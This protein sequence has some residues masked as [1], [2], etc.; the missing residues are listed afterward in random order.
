VIDLRGSAADRGL[1]VGGDGRCHRARIVGLRDLAHRAV[2]IAPD[3]RLVDIGVG[4]VALRVGE[5]G[6]A[7][8]RGMGVP[9]ARHALELGHALRDEPLRGV[10]ETR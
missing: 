5:P 8:A 10:L 6:A 3:D 7:R 9:A 2:G 1:E 4:E